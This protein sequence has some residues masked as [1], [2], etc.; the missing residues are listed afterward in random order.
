MANRQQYLPQTSLV[1]LGMVL[2]LWSH[3]VQL[4]VTKARKSGTNVTMP[5]ESK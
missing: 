5:Y 2:L 1:R 4:R 3:V